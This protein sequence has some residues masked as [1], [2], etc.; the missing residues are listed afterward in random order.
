MPQ[1]L[2]RLFCFIFSVAV[3]LSVQAQIITTVLSGTTLNDGGPATNAALSAPAGIAF[4]NGGNLYI[5]D[6]HENNIRRV[7]V[8]G[9]ITT[10]AGTGSAGFGGDGGSAAQAQF[11]RPTGIA[12]A[13]NGTIYVADQVNNRVRKISGSGIITTVAGTGEYGYTGDGG[14]ATSAQLAYPT[15]LALTASGDLLVTDSGNNRIRKIGINGL[16]STVVGNGMYGFGGD[17]DPATSASLRSP[18]GVVVDASGSI[19]V[20][21]TFNS[22]IR[23]IDAGGTISTV[24]GNGVSSSSG[25]GGQATSAAL[26]APQF[27][28]F[29]AA[30]RLYITQA[31]GRIRRVEVNGIISTIA[32]TGVAD[33]GGD[34]GPATQTALNNPAG[35]VINATG[36]IYIADRENY[37]IRKI[38]TAGIISTVAGGYTGNGG[39]AT[40]SYL[41]SSEF[42]E[43]PTNV[44]VDDRGNLYVT[45]RYMNQIRTVNPDGIITTVV[46]TGVQGYTGD[47]G[48]ASQA[49]LGLP[50]G[51]ATD[52][53]GNLY[54]ND[55]YN[56]RVRKITLDQTITTVG[57]NGQPNFIDNVPFFS[58]A[59]LY[60]PSTLPIDSAGNLYVFS[61]CCV[62]KVNPVGIVSIVA[63]TTAGSG[64]GGDGGLAKNARLSYPNSAVVGENNTLYIADGLNNRVRRVDGNGIITTIAGTG[65]VGSGQENVPAISTP[66][67]PT[68]IARDVSGNIYVA[69][70]ASPRIRKIDRNGIVTTV[71]GSGARGNSGDGGPATN[72]RL[73]KPQEITLDAAGNLYIAD[74]AN[75]NVRKVTYPV[76][77]VLT[78]ISSCSATSVTLTAT[79]SGYGFTYQF[80]PGAVQIGNSNRAVV[81][82]ADV[83]SVTVKT[84]VFGSPPGTA[85]V[86]VVGS[87]TYTLRNGLWSDP[88]VWS[89]GA[90]PILGQPVRVGHLID[91]PVSYQA[92]ART[93]RYINGGS[94]R[95]GQQGRLTLAD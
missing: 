13:A 39:P 84:S 78:A 71:V 41:R 65:T 2:R 79:P 20:A 85:S 11:Y 34:G 19:Y 25:D 58:S 82:T 29:D 80:G 15:G 76:Q 18:T 61:A 17:G 56:S 51:V 52:R 9:V 81:S 75:R 87:E 22:R 23:R 28:T 95:F 27:L 63:G 66:V 4:D 60:N 89:C 88:T 67:L 35:I 91:I 1:I 93:V 26:L 5:T 53:T 38:S 7:D 57:G 32:G 14:P 43:S 42:N 10:I 94:V 37:R 74:A 12:I 44:S 45:D 47:G 46:G 24:A 59:D 3:S 40:N 70:T 21:D 36:E 77:A 68:G 16:I 73:G 55:Q 50:R 33:F 48:P 6:R 49:K 92:T 69:E 83:Y 30:G 31:D 90:V 62:M 72:A 86:S 8:N 54:V 64:F